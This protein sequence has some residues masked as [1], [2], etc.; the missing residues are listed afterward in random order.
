EL[1]LECDYPR[2]ELLKFVY[3][4]PKVTELSTNGVVPDLTGIE[5]M[6]NLKKLKI[7]THYDEKDIVDFAPIAGL[8]ALEEL[9]FTGNDGK[10]LESIGNIKTLKSLTLSGM[11][12]GWADETIDLSGLAG[13]T[14]LEYL[15]ISDVDYSIFSA[16]PN[17]KKLKKIRFGEYSSPDGLD[18]LADLNS[19][20][21][22]VFED[23]ST[24][25]LK[26]VSKLKKLK[27]ITVIESDIE[28]VSEINE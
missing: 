4:M 9:D 15:D 23:Y 25:D 19:L 22:L 7:E 24:V 20:E 17:M 16:I 2:S 28:N 13:C 21:E 6:T 26:G 5:A 11:R 14:S 10:N 27:K 8:K 18:E 1:A 3:S 12:S